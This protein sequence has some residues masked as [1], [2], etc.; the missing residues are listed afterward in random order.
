M[1]CPNSENCWLDD[2][3]YPSDWAMAGEVA[4]RAPA[5]NPTMGARVKRIPLQR[6]DMTNPQW[7][8]SQRSINAAGAIKERSA[9]ATC[10]W[11]TCGGCSAAGVCFRTQRVLSCCH[12]DGEQAGPAGRRSPFRCGTLPSILEVCPSETTTSKN[13]MPPGAP[14]GMILCTSASHNGTGSKTMGHLAFPL[15]S[16]C[17]N[18]LS[19]GATRPIQRFRRHVG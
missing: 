14:A 9:M 7:G 17:R 3:A 4:N 5:T 1:I 10:T 13:V 19:K 6:L 16:E 15:L 11:W 18:R 12:A 8:Q 2:E